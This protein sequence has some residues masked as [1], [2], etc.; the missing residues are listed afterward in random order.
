MTEF[1]PL[2]QDDMEDVPLG[3]IVA[4]AQNGC[5]G[6]NNKLPWHLPND[7]RYFKAQT[8]GR[9]IIMGRKTWESIGKPLPGRT[10]IVMTRQ[11]NFRADGIRVVDSLQAAI[12]LAQDIALIEAADRI[13]VIGG[14]NVFAEAMPQAEYLFLTEV[15]AD[16]DG[17]TFFPDVDLSGYQEESRE[18]FDASGDNPYPYSFIRYRRQ[19]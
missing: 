8:W 11:P 18:D 10:N 13:M 7:L 6:R 17:D 2:L 12:R 19:Q 5:I 1:D 3:I 16:I 14:A 15:H 4:R 9:P